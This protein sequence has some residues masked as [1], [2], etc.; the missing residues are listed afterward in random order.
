MAR[1][2]VI[3]DDREIRA[4]LLRFLRLEGHETLEAE[5]GDTGLAM[6]AGV[7][8][9]LCDVMMPGGPDGFAVLARLRADPS[10]L[11]LPFVFV[12]ASAEREVLDQA[13]SLGADGVLIKPFDLACLRATV[14][15]ALAGRGRR[16]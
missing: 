13:S 4:N 6:A 5:S 15:K 12:T 16:G 10:T 7:D 11:A 2:L 3:E 1:I 9:V 8:L 14:A